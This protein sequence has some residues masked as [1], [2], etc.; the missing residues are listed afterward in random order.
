MADDRNHSTAW[1]GKRCASFSNRTSLTDPD[2][3]RR[4]DAVQLYLMFLFDWQG[5]DQPQTSGAELSGHAAS[6]YF[7]LHQGDK[8]D[9]LPLIRVDYLELRNALGINNSRQVHFS[10]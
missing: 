5:W 2:T 4:L 3:G 6:N 8:W 10:L 7:G 1:P 9:R